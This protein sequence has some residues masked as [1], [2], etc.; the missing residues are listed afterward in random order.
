MEKEGFIFFGPFL[1]T[2][3]VGSEGPRRIR[4]KDV[5]QCSFFLDNLVCL[6]L[7]TLLHLS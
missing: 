6:I 4:G 3:R 7:T 2:V 1:V 5:S